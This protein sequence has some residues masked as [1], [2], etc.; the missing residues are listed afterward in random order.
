LTRK[1]AKFPDEGDPQLEHKE[2]DIS[3]FYP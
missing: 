2:T 3:I 1:C